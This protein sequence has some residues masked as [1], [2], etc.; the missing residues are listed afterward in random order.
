MGATV[1]Q[2]PTP[3][4]ISGERRALSATASTAASNSKISVP[5]LSVT[6]VTRVWSPEV[7]S[8]AGTIPAAGGA[9]GN[10]GWEMNAN[11]VPLSDSGVTRASTIS[12]PLRMVAD[13][14]SDVTATVVLY[15]SGV[16]IGRV[17]A[18]AA[19]SIGTTAATV[20]LT[21]SV[22]AGISVP[23]NGRLQVAYFAACTNVDALAVA[24]VTLLYTSTGTSVG[25][26]TYTI[27]SV[28]SASDTGNSSSTDTARRVVAGVRRTSNAHGVTDVA[29]RT[30]ADV[31]RSTEDQAFQADTGI[32]SVT[33]RPISTEVLAVTADTARRTQANVR[34]ASDSQVVQA[35]TALRSYSAQRVAT[36]VPPTTT[37][38]AQR[39]WSAVRAGSDSQSSTADTGSRVVASARLA[40]EATSQTDVARRTAAVVRVSPETTSTVDAARRVSS[41]VRVAPDSTGGADVAVRAV[42]FARLVSE[43]V[44]V[45]TET[46]TRTQANFRRST[47]NQTVQLDVAQRG[48]GKSVTTFETTEMTDSASKS[49]TY[50]RITLY[51]F[52]AGDEP[53]VNQ[54]RHITGVVRNSDG[55]PYELGATVILIRE[56]GIVVQ[57]QTSSTSVASYGLYDFPRNFLDTHT[58]TVAAHTM[59]A[60]A[61]QQA[62]TP[63][64]LSP[65]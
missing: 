28:R 58:Y 1:T 65:A 7:T 30:Q 10:I 6:A 18:A 48:I 54:V 4:L 2:F 29:S 13:R 60:G 24:L 49:I 5:A 17:T 34:L 20:T 35:D 39:S 3:T 56:D 32:R 51:Q 33:Y 59:V 63:R 11:I 57:T 31:R 45:L 42:T 23:V 46:A 38:A 43:A 25:A 8:S 55:T 53:P 21:V 12:V 61:P 41:Y 15:I 64:A 16:E 50:A 36:E 44:P 47:D 52:Q 19:T 62:V 37:D 9:F 27:N 26:L 40:S 14:A 22:A